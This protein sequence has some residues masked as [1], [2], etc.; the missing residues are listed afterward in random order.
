M[1][2]LVILI[3]PGCSLIKIMVASPKAPASS[4]VPS[5]FNDKNDQALPRSG[6][7]KPVIKIGTVMAA[8][9][10]SNGLWLLGRIKLR[11]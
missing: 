5:F 2:D 10:K 1:A 3:E 8:I 6:N 7:A 9:P 11:Q 4:T